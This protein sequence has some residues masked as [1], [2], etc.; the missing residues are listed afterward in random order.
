MKGRSKGTRFIHLTKA[1]SFSKAHN[2]LRISIIETKMIG[3]Q[4]R[5]LKEIIGSLW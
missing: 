3:K 2:Y 4:I 1:I 5:I